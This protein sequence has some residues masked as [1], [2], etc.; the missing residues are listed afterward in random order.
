MPTT[1][2][3]AAVATGIQP[4][5]DVGMHSVTGRF[6]GTVALAVND[7]IEM[8]K[9]PKGATIQEVVLAVSSLDSSTGVVLDVGLTG[10]D[11]DI[12]IDGATIGRS[13]VG[14]VVRLGQGIS[15]GI[16]TAAELLFADYVMTANDTIDVL[17]QTAATGTASTDFAIVL[18]AIYTMQQKV[19]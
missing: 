16:D 4:R 14:G 15:T 1:Y 13:G 19:V 8:V 3:T 7:I 17:V 10:V 5:A 6:T 9:V 2:Q 18:T 11:A 12:F